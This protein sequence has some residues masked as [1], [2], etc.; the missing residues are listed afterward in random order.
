MTAWPPLAILIVTYNRAATLR[1][2]LRH[3]GE[4]LHYIGPRRVFVAD[5]GSD[6]ETQ[7]LVGSIIGAELVQSNRS[8]LGAN[9]NAGLRAAFGFSDYVLQLQDDMH[10]KAHLDLHPHVE[11]LRDDPTSG[12]IRL[13]GV[14]GHRYTATLEGNHW[15]VSW[16]SDE[17]YIPSDRPHLKHRRFHD[18]YGLYPAGLPTAATEE[19]WCHQCKNIARERIAENVPSVLVPQMET[20][21]LWEHMHWGDR[22]RDKG[23]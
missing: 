11:R 16:N 8:G 9:T 10:L 17:L 19:A 22:W 20:E 18:A 1:G 4:H 3:L 13:W 2:T 7:A 21:R 12:F 15:R 14:G 6:D 23:L 5:D